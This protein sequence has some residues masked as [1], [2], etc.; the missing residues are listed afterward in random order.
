MAV[1]Y[2]KSY[3]TGKGKTENSKNGLTNQKRLERENGEKKKD[4]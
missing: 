2:Y 4:S 1:N 3:K